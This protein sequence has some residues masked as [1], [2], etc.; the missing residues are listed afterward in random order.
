MNR[1]TEIIDYLS[2]TDTPNEIVIAP[3]A[4]PITHINGE[5]SIALNTVFDT[6][7][8]NDTSGSFKSKALAAATDKK[9]DKS[10]SFSFGIRSV[11][12]FRV[13]YIT[14]RGSIIMVVIIIPGTIP[15]IDQLCENTEV[16]KK[17]TD[18]ISSGRPGLITVCGPNAIKN[19]T[20]TYSLLQH[21][22]QNK[23]TII[24]ALE[25]ILTYL[26]RHE[27]SII[28][29]CELGTDIESIAAG[30]H[31]SSLFHPDIMYIGDIKPSDDL[32]EIT[33]AIE[34]GTLVILSSVLLDGKE[35]L[36][37]YYPKTIYANSA[38]D[39]ISGTFT[40]SSGKD[41]KLAVTYN[42]AF[43]SIYSTTTS[44]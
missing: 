32:P 9:R 25:N 12:R 17:A 41:N 37:K 16:A 11:G 26:M 20:F 8:I 10:G 42:K 22:N 1:T 39:M 21:I 31:N 2:N 33:N 35:I 30:I 27:N 13:N 34:N 19:S 7:D 3:N 36:E 6:Q 40:V 14:Q 28:I 24:Y 5:I 23:K 38:I 15:A 29:Q 4:P 44:I 18:I 43:T